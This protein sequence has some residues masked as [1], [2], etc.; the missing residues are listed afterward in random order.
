MG[1]GAAGDSPPSGLDVLLFDSNSMGDTERAWCGA[2]SSPARDGQVGSL[3]SGAGSAAPPE[4]SF[5]EPSTMSAAATM[6]GNNPFWDKG[7]HG[8][9]FSQPARSATRHLDDAPPPPARHRRIHPSR[10]APLSSP[11]GGGGSALPSPRLPGSPQNHGV[12]GLPP[13]PNAHA[14]YHLHQAAAHERRF[15]LLS[16]RRGTSDG[17]LWT[18]PSVVGTTTSSRW[19]EDEYSGLAPLFQSCPDFLRFGAGGPSGPG[20]PSCP[21]SPHGSG[22]LRALPNFGHDADDRRPGQQSPRS[23]AVAAPDWRDLLPVAEAITFG[24]SASP[25]A[26]AAT[27]GWPPVG[28]WTEFA[29]QQF[30]YPTHSLLSAP[31]EA[32]LLFPSLFQLGQVGAAG[33]GMPSR[34]RHQVSQHQ[35]F[36]SPHAVAQ[37][38]RHQQVPPDATAPPEP[39]PPPASQQ[40]P[41]LQLP[42]QPPLPSQPPASDAATPPSVPI[43]PLVAAQTIELAQ[44]IDSVPAR[45][46]A[47][48]KHGITARGAR[49]PT[50]VF[51]RALPPSGSRLPSKRH[52][53]HPPAVPLQ[54]SPRRPH[55]RPATKPL[56][57]GQF[58]GGT[59]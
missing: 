11:A 6:G 54:S 35:L 28:Q 50:L 13:Q 38:Q 34:H 9:L 41:G 24:D 39:Q 17:G 23:D 3:P 18:A 12:A 27:T 2:S 20:P 22:L 33:V 40:Q 47:N 48:V 25:H 46:S 55:L 29:P 57:A 1:P 4:G 30:A 5:L 16:E 19:R 51:A 8:D 52:P 49:Q 10:A 37:Q 42:A 21:G 43:D 31:Q 7:V 36:M 56:S 59:T 14:L 26:T 58:S 45:P 44:L 32:A 53:P 15:R